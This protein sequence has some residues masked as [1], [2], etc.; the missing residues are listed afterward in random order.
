M[1][2][3]E[4][5]YWDEEQRM[6]IVKET[7]NWVVCMVPMIFN[8]RITVASK[9]EHPFEYS[10][11]FCY[12][13]G[14]QAILRAALWDP[15]TERYPTGFKKI[16]CDARA[17]PEKLSWTQPVCEWCYRDLMPDRI[18]HRLKE[19]EANPC[20]ICGSVNQDGIYFRVDPTTVRYPQEDDD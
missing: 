19:P 16:A 6:F 10:A 18:P 14:Q 17:K 2:I 4:A 12:D 9:D 15:E 11:G 13:K 3:Q 7:E 8:E 1:T 5:P 20:C